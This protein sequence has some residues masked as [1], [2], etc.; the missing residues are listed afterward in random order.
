[1]S[2]EARPTDNC[3]DEQQLS[4]GQ[5]STDQDDPLLGQIFAEK[6]KVLEKLGS[7]G[8]GRVYKAEHTLLDRIVALKLLHAHLFSDEHH[9]KRF[10]QEAQVACRMNEQHAITLYDFGIEGNIP[11]LVMQYAEGLT[12]KKLLSSGGALPIERVDRILQQV[13]SAVSQAHSLG[14]IHRD[15]K[16]DNILI[17]KDSAGA[18]FAHVLD[19]GVAKFVGADAANKS[20]ITTQIGLFTGTPQYM[21]PE[22]AEQSD[23]DCRTDIY[24][25]GIVLYEMITGQV[26]FTS[27]SPLGML[28]K[29]IQE[30]PIPVRDLRPHLSIPSG[31]SQVVM[32][33]LAKERENRY[34]TVDQLACAFHEAVK[35]GTESI[36]AYT[37]AAEE[38]QAS[39]EPKITSSKR[40]LLYF[41]AAALFV[42]AAA[43]V[44]MFMQG[45]KG[46]GAAISTVK[47]QQAKLPLL[48]DLQSATPP[49]SQPGTS[50]SALSE[51]PAE[52]PP[53]ETAAP[54]PVPA[55]ADVNGSPAA[56]LGQI[57]ELPA[58]DNGPAPVSPEQQQELKEAPK[59]QTVDE[60]KP[61]L[62]PEQARQEADRLYKE[63]KTLLQEKDYLRAGLLF[64][65]AISLRDSHIMAHLSLGL[66]LLRLGKSEN[67]LKEFEKALSFDP[68]YAPTH[69]NL[70]TYY[71]LAKDP[72]K[73]LTFLRKAITL[74]P[75]TRN[76]AAKDADFDNIRNDP[77]FQKLVS[78]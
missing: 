75:E 21:S 18:D 68:E 26:P 60:N 71:A 53:L 37:P 15:L 43:I 65:K 35:A 45:K 22:Q 59:T 3:S 44:F 78:R 1:V 67:A 36:P 57:N 29:H 31:V 27:D 46:G 51:P 7:G 48:T 58:E 16:P 69:Y 23:L 30:I 4:A 28:M 25:L 74:F 76:W 56:Q 20:V 49:K 73:A 14:I 32:K 34:E 70:A 39:F 63:G 42:V 77:R 24:S 41:R 10:K 2:D 8:M 38:Q 66:C 11:Y 19:F 33:A 9:L 52:L 54:T 61:Q 62:S 64:K 6:Y 17:S 12:L 50:K 72:D 55:G 40:P 13:C 5:K 47:E